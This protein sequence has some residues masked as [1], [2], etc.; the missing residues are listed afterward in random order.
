MEGFWRRLG[1][2]AS[3]RTGAVVLGALVISAV[4][5][6]GL[7]GLTFQTGQDSF[8]DSDS[9]IARDNEAY[10]DLFGGETMIVLF[11]AREGHTIAD[12]FTDANVAKMDRIE[13]ELRDSDAIAS[14]VSPMTALQW[15]SNLVTSG[16]A[17]AVLD[18]AT[19]REPDPA[20][21]PL[22][23]QNSVVSAFRAATAGA[24]GTDLG[25]TQWA[26]FLLFD[27]QGFTVNSDNQLIAPSADQL[28]VRRS[29][30]GFIP[31]QQHAL[32]AAILP[33]NAELSQL[34][35]GEE[36]VRKAFDG[37]SFDNVDYVITGT[38]TF[39][40][41]INDYLQG[42]MLTL[43]A[44][45]L[46]VMAVVLLVAF[47]VR[48]RLLPLAI[49]VVGVLW[50]FSILGLVGIDLSL[51]TI[52]GLPILIGIG[53]DFAIQT[54]N[55]I[56][57]EVAADKS[58]EPFAET[59]QKLGPALLVATIAAVAAF[60]AM[61]ISRVPMI[62]DFGVL[63]SIGIVS[64]FV[65]GLILP[66]SVLGW[67]ERRSPTREF[68]RSERIEKAVVWLSGLPRV[69]V[70]PLVVLAVVIPI[71]GLAV[72]DGL[73]IESDPINWADQGSQSIR[74]ARIFEN[75]T[76]YA[77][78]F[79]VFIETTGHDSNGIFTDQMASFIHDLAITEVDTHPEL[80]E[81][82]SLTTTLSFLIDLPG[83]TPLPPTGRDMLAAYEQAPT[84]IQNLLV[85]DNGNAAQINFRVAP[86][87]LEER[88]V[89]MDQLVH[90]IADPGQRTPIPDNATAA[91]AGLAVV[92]V[93][94]L[95]NLTANRTALTLVALAVVAIW[96]LIRFRSLTLAVL[97]LVPV[98]IAVGGASLIVAALGITLS[99]LT[100]VGGPLII[101]TCGEFTILILTRYLEERNRGLGP[102]EATDVASA[103]TGRAF[104]AS[105][106][107]TIG[108]FGVLYLS[109]LPLLSDFGL[110]VALNIT[111]ALLSAL[112]VLPPIMVAADEVGLLGL[113]GT[114]SR[115]ASPTVRAV[116]AGVAGVLLAGYVV[117]AVSDAVAST[118]EELAIQTVPATEQPVT[119]ADLAP[120]TTETVTTT[121]AVTTTTG[122]TMESTTSTE[123]PPTTLPP[124]PA[125]RPTTLVGGGV[126]DAYV[127]AG[128]D[129]GVARCTADALLA[130]TSEADLLAMGI[131]NQ[132]IP[133][134][135]RD[136]IGAAAEA[137]GVPPE[138]RA[139]VAG[140]EPPPTTTIAEETTTQPPATTL[141]PGPPERPTGL[142]AGAVYDAYVAAGADPGVARCTADA[143]L[144]G[145]S[146]ADLLAMGIANQPMP[147]DVRDLIAAAAEAC[148]VPPEVRAA[149]D[150]AAE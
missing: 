90:D 81:V 45:A 14:V 72:E 18:E 43:G 142:V 144:A 68:A 139:V 116:T 1:V 40:N 39:L 136:L 88:S 85:G 7:G 149:V 44:I 19:A 41:D 96:M 13:A 91:P 57:E 38:P 111:V 104:F 83:T 138:V 119:L 15:T 113:P 58:P 65:V 52:S 89:V 61:R 135:V 95:E 94:L 140:E 16:V 87:S 146:E 71:A 115:F 23:Q 84:D 30:R 132:P 73:K 50:A 2:L 93:G 120:P 137:C 112:V 130:G 49:V 110:I 122:A 123:P 86:S 107:T 26:T 47:G 145:T 63:L 82:S 35:S 133:G 20:A 92:G 97:A 33:G 124:G 9:R 129:P 56:E 126:Y 80:A 29:L 66:M 131:A 147:G 150:A 60:L 117:F 148:G 12:L 32:L 53:I 4:L 55:R 42:G 102:R 69:L 106:L 75:E 27:N 21:V 134:E 5:A 48:W 10:Q 34:G 24:D 77:T 64:L 22:R 46:V 127:A 74:N 70:V 78:T 36:A 141:P 118:D 100:T 8:L 99:P 37:V 3:R 51:V 101:A 62:R 25:N 109:P 79:G 105:A 128:A 108:G 143:L 103:R 31:D 11:T 6:V 17:T 125:E 114:G 76:G 98:L 67:R 59:S 54:H 28:V 121:T